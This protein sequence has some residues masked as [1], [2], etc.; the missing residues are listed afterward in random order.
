[1][2]TRGGVD[3]DAGTG[4]GRAGQAKP[5]EPS[6]PLKVTFKEPIVGANSPLVF[7]RRARFLGVVRVV[8]TGATAPPERVVISFVRERDKALGGQFNAEKKQVGPDT[9]EYTAELMAPPSAAKYKL[10]ATLDSS[11]VSESKVG[12]SVKVEVVE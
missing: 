10:V 9:F 1:M 3:S 4:E 2:V 6:P 8:R 12:A 5:P 11:N 7:A